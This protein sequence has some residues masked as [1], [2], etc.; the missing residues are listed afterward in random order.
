[1]SRSYR[2]NPAGGVT[3]C[4]SEKRDKQRG[5]RCYRKRV[6]MAILRGLEVMPV[7]NEFYRVWSM[8]KDGKRWYGWDNPS[9][10]KLLRK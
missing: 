9:I 7:V 6:R 1:M 10:N 8:G 2:K 3:C 4:K 5:N